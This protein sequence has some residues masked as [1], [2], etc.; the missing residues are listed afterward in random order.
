[1]AKKILGFTGMIGCGK[2]TAADYLL[3]KN[4]GDKIKFSASLTDVLKRIYLPTERANYQILSRILRESFGQDLLSKIVAG[5]A[6][7]S[8]KDLVVIDGIRRPMDIEHLKN[9]AG[10]KLVAIEVGQ[11]TRYE[12]VKKRGDKVGESEKTWEDF[13]KEDLAET[14]V[15]IP[16]IMAQADVTIDN[17]GSLAKF[18]KELDKL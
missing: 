5:D 10:F 8:K 13:Q 4:G 17:N 12:R 6:K 7:N 9:L 2:D 15:T 11:S 18:Y 3:K 16:E 1:M 14:E